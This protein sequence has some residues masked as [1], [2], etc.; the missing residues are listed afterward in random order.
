M[1]RLLDVQPDHRVLEIGTG[2]GYSTALLAHLVGAGG[3]VISLDIDPEMV[4][5]TSRLLALDHRGNVTVWHADGRLGHPPGAPYDRL[6]A[7]AQA[8]H[9]IPA[10]WTGQ[11][12]LG[13]IISLPASS[14]SPPS[15]CD[16]GKTTTMHQAD[17]RPDPIPLCNPSSAPMWS[18]G[19]HTPVRKGLTCGNANGSRV[20]TA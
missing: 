7:W 8:P 3:Q 11:V 2:S 9:A 17:H 18:V 14:R 12:R 5:R 15:P 19:G 10:A 13:G 16:P 1:L 6:V 20:L 4:T